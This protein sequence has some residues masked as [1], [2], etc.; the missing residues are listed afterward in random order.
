[1]NI[2][3]QAIGT[4]YWKQ[5]ARSKLQGLKMD[6]SLYEQLKVSYNYKKENYS[7]QNITAVLY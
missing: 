1:M 5:G 2:L 4:V 7:S 6:M 3:F